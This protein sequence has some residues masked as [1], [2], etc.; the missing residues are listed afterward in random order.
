MKRNLVIAM[1]ALIFSTSGVGCANTQE[2]NASVPEEKPS[3]D[4][5][6]ASKVY[7]VYR[8]LVGQ[9]CEDLRCT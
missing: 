6:E 2:S 3:D 5:Q 7:Y 9:S 1:F 8:N 4:T